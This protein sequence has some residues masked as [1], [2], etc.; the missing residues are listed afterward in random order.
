[1][2]TNIQCVTSSRM[3]LIYL[4]GSDKVKENS[5]LLGHSPVGHNDQSWVGPN[6]KAGNSAQVCLVLEPSPTSP[7][8]SQGLHPQEAGSGMQTR[9]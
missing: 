4:R 8:G 5:L 1:M 7:V 6:T 3:L 2:Y 9:D